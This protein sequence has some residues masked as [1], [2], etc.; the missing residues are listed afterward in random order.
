M[1]NKHANRE[2]NGCDHLGAFY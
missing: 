2:S 1:S